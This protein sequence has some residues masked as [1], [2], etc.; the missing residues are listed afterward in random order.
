MIAVQLS[1]NLHDHR[2]F[3]QPIVGWA[4]LITAP[5]RSSFQDITF[6]RQRFRL[7]SSVATKSSEQKEIKE[8]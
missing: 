6:F 2:S 3:N 5:C 1:I 4:R 7:L 8:K